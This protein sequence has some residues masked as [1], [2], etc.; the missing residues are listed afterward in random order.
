M[1]GVID[2]PTFFFG[3]VIMPRADMSISKAFC[4][5]LLGSSQLLIAQDVPYLGNQYIYDA[6][7]MAL[8][9]NF[10]DGMNKSLSESSRPAPMATPQSLTFTPSQTQRK[11]NIADYVSSVAKIAPDYAPQLVAEFG[12]GAVFDQYGQMLGGIG[13]DAN[14]LGDN[15]AV[16]WITAWEA[17]QGRPVETNPASFGK[18]KAQVARILSEKA[19][20]AMS[21]ADK[22]RY[23]DSLTIQTL[24]LTNQIDQVNGNP[25]M[26]RQLADGI[27]AG[28]KTM[29]FDLDAMTLT[30]D[31]FVSAKGRKTG[32]ADGTSKATNPAA[33]ETA[34]AANASGNSDA[35]KD[36]I[37]Q[38]ALIAAAGGAGLAGVFLFG[39]AM[40][41]KG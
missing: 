25:A 28:A 32:A 21:N 19:L 13:L 36:T 41:R 39:K 1:C 9:Q 15:L 8:Q 7:Q 3:E 12:D 31:G 23:A 34:I 20:T 10:F 38:W 5:V 35:A 14:D 33:V 29:G 2:D 27:K 16:W 30:E 22:Q 26:A 11:K 18:V 24:V 17:A 40:G 6:G 37:T 4:F